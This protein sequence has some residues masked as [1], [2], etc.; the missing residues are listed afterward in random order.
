[1]GASE[2][3][4]RKLD[5]V[6]TAALAL[7]GPAAAALPNLDSLAHR[8]MVG[9]LAYLFKLRSWSPPARLA[10]LVPP[11]LAYPTG[12]TRAS[13]RAQQQW[14]PAQFAAMLPPRSPA[15]FARAFP[16]C[17][18]EVWNDLPVPGFA[19]EHLQAFKVA[20]NAHL[21]G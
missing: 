9:A 1:M 10:A 6:Q 8:R 4:L 21:R 2:T 17:A 5:A 15:Y 16:H 7:V 20:V 3:H 13:Q 19:P 14:H 18:V 11:P 12:R